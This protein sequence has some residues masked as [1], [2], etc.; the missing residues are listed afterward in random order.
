MIDSHEWS[1]ASDLCDLKLPPGSTCGITSEE[2]WTNDLLAQKP[3]DQT[4]KLGATQARE[5]EQ[6][7]AQQA[8]DGTALTAIVM[9]PQDG[10]DQS[11]TVRSGIRTQD[12]QRQGRPVETASRPCDAVAR[13]NGA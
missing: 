3:T 13:A 10:V 9:T 8:F 2:G 6:K 5:F 11:S 12:S 4:G 7:A 1:K